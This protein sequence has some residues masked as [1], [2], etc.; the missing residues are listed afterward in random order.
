MLVRLGAP[1]SC[2]SGPEFFAMSGWDRVGLASSV[3]A[4]HFV[5]VFESAGA[6]KHEGEKQ[7]VVAGVDQDAGSEGSRDE[8]RSTQHEADADQEQEG[9][10]GVAGLIGMHKGE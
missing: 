9:A 8:S 10:D 3:C 6:Q 4:L 1:A 5:E 7:K 2:Q